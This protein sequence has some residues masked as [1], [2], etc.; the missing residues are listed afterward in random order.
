MQYK[1]KQT[2]AIYPHIIILN[3]IMSQE[4]LVFR[5]SCHNLLTT[6]VSDR[7]EAEWLADLI[8][9]MPGCF[10]SL[11]TVVETQFI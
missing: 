3:K 6:D 2:S 11:S 8:D 1:G 9:S 10:T 7:C 4:V 5:L